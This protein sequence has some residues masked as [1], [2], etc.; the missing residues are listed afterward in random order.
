MSTSVGEGTNE[1]TLYPIPALFRFI[2]LVI[3][4]VSK[5]KC[6]IYYNYGTGI[7]YSRFR[8]TSDDGKLVKTKSTAID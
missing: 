8:I 6:K 5:T 4:D 2:H 7:T 1:Y 3:I